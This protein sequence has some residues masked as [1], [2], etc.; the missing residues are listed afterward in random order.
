MTSLR[1]MAAALLIGAAAVP[2]TAGPV[3]WTNWTTVTDALAVLGALDVDGTAVEVTFTGISSFVQTSGGTNYW[4]P[5]SPYI[6]AAVSNAPPA[7]DIIGLNTGGRATIRFSQAVV[8]P[9][10]ALVSWNSNTV[11]F[12]V[13]IEVLSFGAGYWGSGTPVLNAA[14]TGFFGSGEVHGVIRLPG[15]YDSISF[16]HTSENWHGLTIGV[17]ALADGGNPVPEPASLA[18]VG[19]ALA[20]LTLTRRSRR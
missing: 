20:G 7:T 11:D 14:G 18:L 19:L 12:G 1:N 4:S 10:V 17:T 2:A 6:S 15:T 9:L 5:S 13:P 3:S 8:D 16:T